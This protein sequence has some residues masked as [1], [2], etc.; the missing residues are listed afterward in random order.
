MDII[1]SQ[2]SDNSQT[3]STS[4]H[5]FPVFNTGNTVS[6][7]KTFD[8]SSYTVDQYRIYCQ[9]ISNNKKEH[10][11]YRQEII[12]MI[13]ETEKMWQKILQG[14]DFQIH[15][16]NADNQYLIEQ[17]LCYVFDIVL[18]NNRESYEHSD[19]GI[20]RDFVND[21]NMLRT[22]KNNLITDFQQYMVEYAIRNFMDYN[23]ENYHDDMMIA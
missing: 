12:N 8:A 10:N 2:E 6:V 21:P 1:S 20:I 14:L 23:Y 22:I 3:S 19:I 16:H 18:S 5:E 13:V 11:K 4:S 9:Y 17:C 7:R 15:Y